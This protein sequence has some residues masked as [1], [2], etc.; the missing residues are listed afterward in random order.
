MERYSANFRPYFAGILFS[1]LNFSGN[2]YADVIFQSRKEALRFL[3][4][5]IAGAARGKR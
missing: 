3:P 2:S 5:E 4:G 1:P